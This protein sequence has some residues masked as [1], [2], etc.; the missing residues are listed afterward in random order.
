MTKI[1]D[2]S[3]E[4]LVELIRY[5]R[6]INMGEGQRIECY[7]CE[8]TKSTYYYICEKCS[9]LIESEKSVVKS[10]QSR[11]DEPYNK[12]DTTAS[13]IKNVKYKSFITSNRSHDYISFSFNSI[14]DKKRETDEI[15]KDVKRKYFA[16]SVWE[17]Q[18][19]R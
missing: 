11:T 16:D 19:G 4:E 12:S 1:E 18:F 17:G 3:K 15:I 7:V 2:L 5:N 10:C 13:L 9:K 14:L 8:N 6:N